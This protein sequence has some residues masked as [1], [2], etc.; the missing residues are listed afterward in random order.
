L[1][2]VPKAKIRWF[3]ADFPI[4]FSFKGLKPKCLNIQGLT[5]NKKKIGTKTKKREFTVTKMMFKPKFFKII[6]D[7]N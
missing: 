7:K 3:P 2:L 5:C 1:I 4:N 6:Y